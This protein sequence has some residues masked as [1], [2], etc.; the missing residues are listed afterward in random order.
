M[1]SFS[2]CSHKLLCKYLVWSVPPNFVPQNFSAFWLL[3]EWIDIVC[4]AKLESSF[5][6]E[7][8]ERGCCCGACDSGD[9][10]YSL[11][12]AGWL[13]K[14][15]IIILIII[16]TILFGVFCGC[17]LIVFCI[18]LECNAYFDCCNYYECCCECCDDFVD[19]HC[20]WCDDD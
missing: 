12:D 20:D 15:C 9:H 6:Y 10:W 5:S 2:S 16:S 3:L 18:S 11:E 7:E 8:S 13:R 14:T 4:V 17:C 19:E 1:I